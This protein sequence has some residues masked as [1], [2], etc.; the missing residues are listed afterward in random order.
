VRGDI[1]ASSA[2]V[3]KELNAACREK[4]EALLGVEIE[5]N[6]QRE[7]LDWLDEVMKQSRQTAEAKLEQ[8]IRARLAEE[9]RLRREAVQRLEQVPPP[10]A[11]AAPLNLTPPLSVPPG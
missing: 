11:Q 2:R 10:P 1:E 6:R 3:I 8:A 7:Q 9:E 4:F 5:L